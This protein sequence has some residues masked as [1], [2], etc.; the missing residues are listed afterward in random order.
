MFH[1]H[2]FKKEG[3]NI[4]CECGK[5]KRL[6]CDHDWDI[7]SEKK[8]NSLGNEQ[9]LQILVCKKCG[10]LKSVNIITGVIE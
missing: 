1:K 5:I 4:W 10:E 9:I 7:H 6:E 8:I 2:N 3:N